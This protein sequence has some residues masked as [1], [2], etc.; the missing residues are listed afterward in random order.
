M[1]SIHTLKY[2]SA[3]KR[4]EALTQATRIKF[5]NVKLSERSQTQKGQTVYDSIDVKCPEHAK[6]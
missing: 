3:I 5:K 4:N 1:G 2:D 6:P